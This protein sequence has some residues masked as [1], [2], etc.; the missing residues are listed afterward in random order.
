MDPMLVTIVLALS[1]TVV[2]MLLG[3]LTMSGGGAAD[4]EFSTK[5]MWTRVAFQGLTILLL[6]AAVWLR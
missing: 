5:L 6:M 3:L 4:R 1:A 2:T